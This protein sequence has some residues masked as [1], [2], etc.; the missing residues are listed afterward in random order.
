MEYSASSILYLKAA[1]AIMILVQVGYVAWLA[2]R[3]NR[4]RKP[5]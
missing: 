2:V 3:W 1:Y 5:E 4:T